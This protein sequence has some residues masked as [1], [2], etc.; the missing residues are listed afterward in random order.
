M[1]QPLSARLVPLALIFPTLLAL[2]Q[3]CGGSGEQSTTQTSTGS[4]SGSGAGG[5][6]G[7]S[8]TG[9][10]GGEGGTIF[11]PDGGPPPD[12]D[13]CVGVQCPPDQHCTSTMNG[14]MCVNNTCA[15]LM[16]S[17][18]EICE[19]TPGGGAVCKDISCTA[20]VDCPISQ[21]CN[22]TICVDDVCVALEQTC[23]GQ[24]LHEC[25]P[26]GSGDVVKYTCGST[27][28]FQSMCDDQGNGSA[29]CPCEDDWD[30]PAFTTC[31]VATCTGTGKAP[32]CTL[33]PAPFQSVL[34]TNEISWGGTGVADKNATGRPFPSSSQSCMTPIVANLD[35]DNGDGLINELD[36]PEVV[37]MTYCNQEI[38]QNGI[39]RAIHGGGPSK[40]QDYFATCGA[41][42]WH[43]GDPT[44]M[45][46]ACANATG[47]ST[48]SLAVGDLDG[49][50]KPEIVVP[51]ENSGLS[52]LDNTGVLITAS[53]NNQWSGYINPAPAIANIDNQG[54]AEIVVGRHVFTLAHDANNKLVFQDRF[55]GALMHG[56]NTQGPIPCIANLV[57]DAQQEIIAGS[58]VYK[59]PAPPPGVTKI[60]DCPAGSMDDFCTGKLTVVW[61]GQTVNG[62]AALPDGRRDGF[63]AVADIL[64]VDQALAPGPANPLDGKPEVILIN[65]GYLTIFAGDTGL[66]KRSIDL[67][68]GTLG[69]APNVD[70]FDGDGFPEVGTAFGLRYLMIDLQDPEPLNCPVWS[71]PLNDNVMGMQ[72]NA[73]RTPGGMCT[74]D[75]D[76]AAGAVCNTIKGSCVCLHNGW[77]R[78]TEDD[79]SRVTGSSVFDF[80]GDGAAEVVYNDE[81]YFRIYDGTT[82]DVLFKHHSPSRTRIENPIIADVDNDGNAEIVFTS[83]NEAASCTEGVNYPN[84][85]FVW[86][87]A[88]DTW[89]S[90]RRIWNQ[91]AHHV[92]NAFEGGGIPTQEPESWKT[93]NGRVYNTYRSNPRS[94]GVAPDLTVGGVQVSSPNATC[95]QLSSDID[96]TVEIDNIGDLRVGPG[97][98]LTF[99]G[100]WLNPA[101]DEPLYA[102][103]M[104][105]PLTAVIQ[106]S[107]EPGGSILVTVSYAA[108]NNAPGVLPDSVRVV[109]DEANQAHECD[110]TN[111]EKTSPVDPGMPLPDLRLTLGLANAALCPTP[112]IDTT[113][114]NDGSAPASNVVVRYYAGDPNQGGGAIHE[115]LVPGPIPGGG[116]T[117]DV[118]ASL[119]NFPKNL[120]ITIYAIVDP[121]NVIAE[122]NDGNNKAAAPNKI[123]CIG[124]N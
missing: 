79:S 123:E 109:V 90:A 10:S 43:E 1:S 117:V 7:S 121:D 112:T 38:T 74:T 59:L 114:I 82:A 31:D 11:M 68:A 84:G 97:V 3:G 48:A 80:N 119:S 105:V 66:I 78:V 108:A 14:S 64:G 69:G 67:G 103:L 51:N 75:A 47:N 13:L 50:G 24:E 102:N 86:G 37:F 34:P 65:N 45:A 113:V 77:A 46:C 101:L 98:V 99:Y 118:T 6:G 72:G 61:D 15:D 88:S 54:F 83:N 106:S 76:C 116:G 94:Y 21:Y 100:V 5:T 36:F 55:S 16:C 62:A 9:G 49:D 81:C 56:I 35:D 60:A 22:G 115:E 27:G 53:A 111:N 25:K 57:G 28:Y 26:N 124:V 30:C 41:T 52:I 12:A 8:P 91:H 4:P 110:E 107:I 85:I 44:N 39:V 33:Q 23:V 70:D 17:P 87:D 2:A 92:T 120:L 93:Y 104:Q 42:V 40:G 20:D 95:G 32:T 58:S 71:N 96:I 73:A 122:C 19:P 89:V 29:D 18:T 63:C